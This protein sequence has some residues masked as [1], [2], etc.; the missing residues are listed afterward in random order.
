[1]LNIDLGAI[2]MMNVQKGGYDIHL[3]K[4]HKEKR[5]SSPA[6]NLILHFAGGNLKLCN[7][8]KTLGKVFKASQAKELHWIL[9]L[10]WPLKL[11]EE[12]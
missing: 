10:I 6:K 9:I 11:E 5:R 1:M 8:A 3:K 12:C 7:Y 4:E 2:R